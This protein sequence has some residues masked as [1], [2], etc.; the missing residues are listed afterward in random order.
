MLPPPAPEALDAID[1]KSPA[2]GNLMADRQRRRQCRQAWDRVVRARSLDHCADLVASEPARFGKFFRIDR[3]LLTQRLGEKSHHQAR[4]E[5]PR[6]RG[7]IAHPSDLDARFFEDFAANRF[8]GSLARFHEPGQARKP[9][10]RA[11][12]AAAEKAALTPDRE[13][14]DDRVDARE[15]VCLA[16]RAVPD[17]AS[18]RDDTWGTA[19]RA[20]AMARMPVDQGAC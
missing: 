1:A 6:L 13:H 9:R 18:R 15:M 17:P 4:W 19:L 11:P 8:L 20:E 16:I 12:T 14:D 3:D 10:A 2:P 7:E 5:W